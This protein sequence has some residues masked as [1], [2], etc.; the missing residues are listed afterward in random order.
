MSQEY[1]SSRS[2]LR[3]AESERLAL[4]EELRQIELEEK[5]MESQELKWATC[6]VLSLSFFFVFFSK[7]TLL[8]WII[9]SSSF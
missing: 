8:I 4:E 1:D 6:P 3:E 9:F 7:S 2:K 5:E